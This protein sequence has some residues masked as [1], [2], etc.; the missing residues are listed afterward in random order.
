MSS[1]L[2]DKAR[3]P[4]GYQE[5]EAARVIRAARHSDAGDFASHLVRHLAESGAKGGLHFAP[6]TDLDRSEVR[7]ETERR[8][9]TPLTQ[10]GWG[11]VWILQTSSSPVVGHVELRGSLL[12]AGLHRA[13]LSIG[14]EAAHRGRGEG[15]RLTHVALAF[16]VDCPILEWIDLRVFAN[17][18]PARRLYRG[19][20][21]SQTGFVSAAFRMTDG[22]AIDDVLMAKRLRG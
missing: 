10:P 1:I 12:A 13:E 11:R 4:P 15:Q 17:N 9:A 18:E 21:F 2:H 14:I 8:W 19:L 20:G 22:T 6:V 3:E 16:A 7:Q 5:P